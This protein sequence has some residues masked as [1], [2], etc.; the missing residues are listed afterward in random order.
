M[1]NIWSADMIA[2]LLRAEKHLFNRVLRPI[3]CTD[4]AVFVHFGRIVAH[5][6]AWFRMG[7][8]FFQAPSLYLRTTS[9]LNALDSYHAT[10]FRS[11]GQKNLLR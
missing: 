5:R 2:T 11:H 4:C 3:T 6:P 7:A 8:Q 1:T 10:L 9:F